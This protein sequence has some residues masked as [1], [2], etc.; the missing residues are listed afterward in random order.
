MH[1]FLVT[2]FP[3]RLHS[4]RRLAFCT[5]V[6]RQRTREIVWTKFPLASLWMSSLRRWFGS[7]FVFSSNDVDAARFT[8]D[9][10]FSGTSVKFVTARLSTTTDEQASKVQYMFLVRENFLTNLRNWTVAPTTKKHLLGTCY[11]RSAV[12]ELMDPN[13]GNTDTKGII[14][15]V[16]VLSGLSQLTS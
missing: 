1:A 6:T 3:H 5:A 12:I 14:M 11:R 13:P 2:S 15:K 4:H 9:R 8:E 10:G 16:S 7:C